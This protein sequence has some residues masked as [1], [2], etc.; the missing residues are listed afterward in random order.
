MEQ[1]ATIKTTSISLIIVLFLWVSMATTHYNTALYEYEY[2]FQVTLSFYNM[3][4]LF[5][6]IPVV[7]VFFLHTYI[8]AFDKHVHKHGSM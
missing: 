2:N 5:C 3:S 6:S 8:C 4:N 1:L 7:N